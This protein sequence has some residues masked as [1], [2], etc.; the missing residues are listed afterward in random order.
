MN[1]IYKTQEGEQLIHEL[2][3]RQ[4]KRLGVPCVDIYA[5][6]RFGKTHILQTGSSQGTPVVLFHGGNSTAAFSLLQN[7]HLIQD[8]LVYAPDTIGHPGKSAQ[9]T[10]SSDTLAY[11]QWASDVIDSLGLGKA[12]CMG[13]SFGGGIVMKLMCVS[14]EKIEKAV[15]LVPAGISNASKAKLVWSMGIPMMMYLV[16]KKERWFEK[17]FQPMASPGEPI[18]QD[19]LEMM[20]T[21][22]HHVSVNP[23]MPSNV[24]TEE[25]SSFH[26][27]VLLLAGELDALFP[28]KQVIERAKRILPKVEAHLLPGC[29]HL[30]YTS[31]KRTQF[32]QE[33]IRS[34]LSKHPS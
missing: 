20:R 14:P 11:G 22:F 10:L 15:L 28:G 9:M 6:T 27:P 32:V 16:S 18:D 25:I 21:T 7:L 30:Y 34:F 2:Y 26:A 8:H 17:T 19:T 12:V 4:V 33:I 24:K 23:N 31:K 3:D 1:G 13:E 5:E 29:G